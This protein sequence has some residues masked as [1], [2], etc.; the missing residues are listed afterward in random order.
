[1]LARRDA[2]NQ[3]TWNHFLFRRRNVSFLVPAFQAP[4]Y[5]AASRRL[6]RQPHYAVR[7]ASG[8]IVGAEAEELGL[9]GD[10]IG[11]DDFG[12]RDSQPAAAFGH[13]RVRLISACC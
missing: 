12:M 11:G 4:V 9:A 1:M 3:V 2:G 10:T 13:A 8:Q 7:I 5:N 6:A